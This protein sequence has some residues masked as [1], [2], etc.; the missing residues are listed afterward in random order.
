MVKNIP[1]CK[2]LAVLRSA[3]QARL[4]IDFSH[5][6]TCRKTGIISICINFNYTIIIMEE[7]YNFF[8]FFKIIDDNNRQ[9]F[10]SGWIRQF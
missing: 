9:S 3:T 4:S 10:S 1:T 7:Q 6:H 5:T 2:C 8:F